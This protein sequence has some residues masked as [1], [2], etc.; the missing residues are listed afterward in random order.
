MLDV[1]TKAAENVGGIVKLAEKLGMKHQ[2][3]YSWDKV[4]AERVLLIADLSGESPHTIRPDIY[5]AAPAPSEP[6]RAA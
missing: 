2:S 4:P 5:P 1:V 6:V 3:F